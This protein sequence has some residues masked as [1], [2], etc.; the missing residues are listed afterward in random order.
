MSAEKPPPYEVKAD[1]QR[2]AEAMPERHT[3]KGGDTATARQI[4]QRSK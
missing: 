4:D 3:V 1:P 2:V